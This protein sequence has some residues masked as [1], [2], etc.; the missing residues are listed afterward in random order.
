MRQ[1]YFSSESGFAT[2]IALV[3]VGMLTLIGLAALSTSD[4]EVSIAGNELQEMRAFYAAE[5]GLE[6]AAANL[7]VQ[8]ENTGLPPTEMPTSPEDE[9]INNCDITYATVNN[10]PD[11]AEQRLLSK[12]SLAGLHALVNS[13]TISAAAQNPDNPG[14]IQMS[15][16]FETA[17]V[18]IFQFAVFYGNDLE[19][20]PGP[21]MNLIG[22]VHS[23]GNLWLQAGGTLRMDSYVTA[24]GNIY[25]GRKGAGGV[26]TGDV[27]VK[28]ASGNYVSMQEASG[29]LDS[30]DTHWYDSSVAR[31]QDRVQDA[32]HGQGQLNLPLTTTDGDAHKVIERGTGNPDSYEHKAGLKIINGQALQYDDASEVWVDVTASMVADGALTFNSDQFYDGRELEWVDAIELDIEKLYDGGYDPDNGVIYTAQDISGNYPALRLNNAEELDGGLT[33]ASANP[34]Y[35]NGNFNSNNKKAASILGDAVSFLSNSW[36]DSKSTLSKYSRVATE[37]SV[38]ASIMTGNMETTDANYNGGFEN[39]PRFLEVWS[40]K[41]FNWKGSMVNMWHAVQADG[42]WNGTYYSPP[43]RNWMYDTD[44]DD[45]HQL[46][47]ET[48]MVRVFQNTGWKQNYVGTD[49]DGDY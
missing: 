48:P 6:R 47:P 37:T 19:I 40:G 41:P 2:L 11:S 20:A 35:T 36:D 4:D 1:T 15:Q 29:W 13:F 49:D 7:Q 12:G 31:W 44:L 5:S 8:W 30:D 22:R 46:P 38:N 43:I 3:M 17:L 32:A 18:P 16:T 39:L 28:D 10:T 26:S 23:N 45:P 42:L 14:K 27:L 24:S 34:V 33:I 21:D 9:V 25:H